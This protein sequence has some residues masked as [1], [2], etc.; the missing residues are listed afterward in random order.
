ML[1]RLLKRIVNSKEIWKDYDQDGN[2]IIIKYYASLD[3]GMNDA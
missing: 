1:K 3:A 2:P